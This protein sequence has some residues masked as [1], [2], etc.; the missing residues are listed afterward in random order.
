MEPMINTRIAD[1]RYPFLI[2]TVIVGAAIALA[3]AICDFQD[4]SVWSVT[5]TYGTLFLLSVA[6]VR[7]VS[8]KLGWESWFAPSTLY[9]IVWISPLFFHSLQLAPE[10]LEPFTPRT[11]G[12]IIA[13]FWSFSLGG[14]F[15]AV[16]CGPSRTEFREWPSRILQGNG[17]IKT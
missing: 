6:L 12:I 7:W 3:L 9:G 16:V 13:S 1:V 11:W 10:L 5:I 14:L 4:G 17:G 2:L 8:R 15:M